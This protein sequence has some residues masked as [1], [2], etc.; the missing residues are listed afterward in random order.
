MFQI[1]APVDGSA[2]ALDAVRWAAREAMARGLPLRLLHAYPPPPPRLPAAVD[3]ESRWVT[4]MSEHGDHVLATASA[5]AR[6]AAP[7]VD[8]ILDQRMGTPSQVVVEASER[9]HAVVMG[10]RGLGGF[11]GLLAGSLTL[12]MATHSH[13]PV[14]V[15]HG[16]APEPGPVV[17]GVDGSPAGDA[18]LAFA[19]DHA[20]H[21]GVGLRAVHAWTDT[22]YASSWAPLPYLARW[23]AIIEQEHAVLAE[24]LAGWN[25]KY[26]EV[27]VERVVVRDRPARALLDHADDAQLVVVGSRGH[28]PLRGVVIGSTAQSVLHHAECPVAV[29]PAR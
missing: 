16:T 22:V 13:S 28:S 14:V 20:A 23:D 4:A 10:S 21:H 19:F 12:T 15:I 29:I 3:P 6:A 1:I 24:R 2:P 5:V 8:P 26:P 27:P 18:A 25:E 11:R 17:V 9:A 7:G